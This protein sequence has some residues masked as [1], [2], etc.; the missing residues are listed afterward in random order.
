MIAYHAIINYIW[1]LNTTESYT[2]S[3]TLFIQFYSKSALPLTIYVLTC[4][5]EICDLSGNF[6][7][8]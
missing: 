3:D 2:K 1:K 5:G 6:I 7:N 4:F 8:V